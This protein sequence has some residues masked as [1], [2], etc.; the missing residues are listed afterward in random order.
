MVAY[1]G[2]AA[3]DVGGAECAG[4]AR[5]KAA[6]GRPRHWTWAALM[7]R[8]FDLDVLACPRCAGRLR[9]IATVEEPGVVRKILAHLGLWL[10]PDTP[11]PAPPGSEGSPGAGPPNAVEPLREA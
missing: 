5:N 9:L 1:R 3:G 4:V 8:A 7:R 11:G 2:G 10:S 6:A